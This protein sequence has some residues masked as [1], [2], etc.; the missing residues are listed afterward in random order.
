MRTALVVP[1]NRQESIQKFLRVWAPVREHWDSIIVVEDNPEKTFDIDASHHYAWADIK[2]DLGGAAHMISR[3]DSSVRSYGFLVAYRL[4][5]DIIFTMDDDCYP[6]TTEHPAWLVREH[7]NNLTRTSR[8]TN[9]VPGVR[10]RGMP[11]VNTGTLDNVAVSVGLWDGN[12]DYDALQTLTGLHPD[13]LTLPDTRV[14]PYGQYFPVC[15]MNVAFRRDFTPACYFVLQGEGQPFRRFDDIWFGVIAKK[16]CDHLGRVMTCGK[17]YVWHSRASDPMVNLVKEAP[18][19]RH[20]EEF[21]ETLHNIP[22]AGDNP[23]DCMRDI[24][25]GLLRAPSAEFHHYY[26]DLGAAIIAWAD[27]FTGNS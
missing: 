14:M 13:Q 11:Y 20:H 23:A 16:I 17:P 3:R 1:T 9:A 27:W 10:T 12:P 4:G 15:G 7:V 6:V 5:A 19:I 24:G 18:G 26:D 25:T 22:L 8:W 21:W 2:A